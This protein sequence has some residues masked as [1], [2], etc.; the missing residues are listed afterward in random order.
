M[1]RQNPLASIVGHRASLL[2]ELFLN[3]LG[4]TVLRIPD[5]R[6]IPLDYVAVFQH[7]DRA[8]AIVGVEVKGTERLENGHFSMR[9]QWISE[10]QHWNIPVLLL[11]VDVKDN[12][13]FY[14]FADELERQPS[15]ARVANVQISVLNA[16]ENK[17]RLLQ[18]VFQGTRV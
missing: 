9:Q 6:E 12:R 8:T 3:E 1:P 5:A 4:A 16:T 15:R 14:T 11:V 2:A 10:A 18:R 7:D 17:D 13:V